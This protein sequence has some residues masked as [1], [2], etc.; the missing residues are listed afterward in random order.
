MLFTIT[1]LN[2]LDR[3]WTFCQCQ[4]RDIPMYRGRIT[5]HKVGWVIGPMSESEST[6]FLLEFS[7]SVDSISGTYYSVVDRSHRSRSGATV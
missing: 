5:L 7:H 3:L 6:R 2:H 1:N 4:G